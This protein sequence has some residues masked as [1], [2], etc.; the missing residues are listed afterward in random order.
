MGGFS[1]ENEK[2]KGNLLEMMGTTIKEN[3]TKDADME[4][5]FKLTKMTTK[6]KVSG[7]T[8]F[9]MVLAQPYPKKESKKK[10]SG[11]KE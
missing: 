1:K 10:D 2:G 7:N 11:T 5:A 4:K 9:K 8:T 6:S 3:G